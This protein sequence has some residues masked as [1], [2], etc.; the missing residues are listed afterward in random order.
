MFDAFS[1]T[2]TI[3]AVLSL[4]ILIVWEHPALKITNFVQLLHVVIL[5]VLFNEY[6]RFYYPDLA[7]KESHLVSLPVAKTMGDLFEQMHSPDF[8]QLNKI[9]HI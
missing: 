3:I 5:G 6:L 7:L 8:S 1:P 2:A 4:I 9:F